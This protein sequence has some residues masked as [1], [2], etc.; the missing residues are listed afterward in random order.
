L[1]ATPL[2]YGTRLNWAFP[3]GAEDTQR[4]EIWQSPTTS[5]DD[6]AKLGDYAYPQ[7][8]HEIHGLAAGVSFYYWARLVDRSGNVGPWYPAGVGVNG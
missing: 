3:P 6:A 8:E 1:S 4:T 7:A 2:V 5:H